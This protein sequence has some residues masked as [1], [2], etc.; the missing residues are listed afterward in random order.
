MKSPPVRS[1][2]Y[3]GFAKWAV[4]SRASLLAGLVVALAVIAPLGCGPDGPRDNAAV[5]TTEGACMDADGDLS[6]G[7]TE[8][9]GDGGNG[10]GRVAATQE[11]YSSENVEKL[12]VDAMARIGNTDPERDNCK[13]FVKE[14]AK[15]ALNIIIPS[16]TTDGIAWQGVDTK[17]S[18][19]PVRQVAQWLATY[20][21][22]AAV[23]G[24]IAAADT[25]STPVSVPNCDPQVLVIYSVN[26]NITA[27][28]TNGSSSPLSV[29]SM[30][31]IKGT[32]SSGTL[33]GTA[34]S[35][36]L[37]IQNGS[38]ISVTDVR[39]V[40]LS[41]S[42]IESD[43]TTANRGD[44]IQ[45]HGRFYKNGNTRPH[46]TFVLTDGQ[47]DTNWVNANWIPTNEVTQAATTLKEAIRWFSAT[48]AEGFTVY[49]LN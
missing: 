24:T 41:Y 31:G 11:V 44:M 14:V 12:I 26:T 27:T 36:S 6:Y 15:S 1:S 47:T 48:D 18:S 2:H 13:E 43:W 9:S 8:Y 22:K 49:R 35:W 29:T 42:R 5:A 38:K 7:S 33:T 19:T 32:V 39:V 25:Y 17:A 40:V 23:P 3:I 20:A 34:G 4:L 30:D 45:M 37:T 28:L 21:N 46:S 10:G 16:T